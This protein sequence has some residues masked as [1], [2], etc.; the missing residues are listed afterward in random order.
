MEPR[1]RN[2]LHGDAIAS[3]RRDAKS[4]NNT[5]TSTTP[6][7]PQLDSTPNTRSIITRLRSQSSLSKSW[8]PTSNLQPSSQKNVETDPLPTRRQGKS[9]APLA[10]V[11]NSSAKHSLSID[12]PSEQ[13]QGRPR[14]S[15]RIEGESMRTLP[16]PSN[17]PRE[18]AK[19]NPLPPMLAPLHDPPEDAQIIPSMA[20]ERFRPGLSDL[21]SSIPNSS[22]LD[23]DAPPALIPQEDENLARLAIEQATPVVDAEPNQAHE[24]VAA[25]GQINTRKDEPRPGKMGK[26]LRWTQEET[27]FLLQGVAQFGIGGWK[28]ILLHPEYKFQDGRNSIDLKDRFRTCFPDEY[29]KSGAQK[30]RVESIVDEN[31]KRRGRGSRT[32]VELAKMGLNDNIDFPKLD[33]RERKNFTKEEDDALLRGY[34]K[35]PAQWKKIQSDPEFG[36][37]HR[38]RTDLRDRFRNRFPQR[39]KEAG[40]KH[41]AKQAATVKPSGEQDAPSQEAVKDAVKKPTQPIIQTPDKQPPQQPKYQMSEELELA[42]LLLRHNNSGREALT[43]SSKENSAYPALPLPNTGMTHPYDPDFVQS[44]ISGEEEQPGSQ[45]NRDMFEWAVRNRRPATETSQ[46]RYEDSSA[47]SSFD[48]YSINP[49]LPDDR[50]SAINNAAGNSTAPLSRILNASEEQQQSGDA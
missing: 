43:S 20:S 21:H 17:Y 23:R 8:Q 34:L 7:D 5:D 3:R 27:T 32:T 31:G 36:L 19:Q 46:T 25:N 12:G 35:Y 48:Q 11:L 15:R 14:K 45:L 42:T 30:G 50:T 47:L 1:V 26:R 29:R 33:R 40:Y 28:K 9:T 6:V 4:N 37:T 24:L 39:F 13:G 22:L 2:L 41:K 10:E 16:R 18:G 44:P 49:L 38:T